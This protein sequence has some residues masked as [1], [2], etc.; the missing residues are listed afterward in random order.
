MVGTRHLA[1]LLHAAEQHHARLVLVGDPAQLPE[2]DAGGL[3]G[4][5][6]HH[7][8]A[9]LAGNRRQQADW[10][11]DA[12]AALRAG[13]IGP[14]LGA[15][16][17]HGRVHIDPTPAERTDRIVEDYLSA[18]HVLTGPDDVLVLTAT[19]AHAA[20]LNTAIRDT[21]HA[22]GRL[23]PDQLDVD[24]P[25]G[26]RG[27]S[28]GDQVIVTRNDPTRGLLNGDRATVTTLHPDRGALTILTRDGR[29]L[30]LP[31]PYLADGRLDH[32]YALT[33][34]KAQG[35]TSQIT[36]VAAAPSMTRETAYTALS[37]GRLGNYLYLTPDPNTSSG[38]DAV[39]AWITDTALAQT[40]HAIH[41]TG[42]HQLATDLQSTALA[43]AARRPQMSGL[44]SAP[45]PPGHEAAGF[46]I[47]R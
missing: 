20:R 29:D 19:R 14:A 31:G 2:I 25:D 38:A 10:E 39:G 23:G 8:D 7:A 21:L 42:A 4:H 18:R 40:A 9:A 15:Y 45:Q 5:V 22:T 13:Q 30:T 1:T 46:G 17:Q 27:Y 34:H 32:A 12:L 16:L 6:A 47:G 28:T 36:L 24:T 37:R 41:R 3:F 11:R 33:V 26:P 44:H 35:Q 43:A